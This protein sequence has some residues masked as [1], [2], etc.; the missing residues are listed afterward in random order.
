MY[1]SDEGKIYLINTNM[2][3]VFTGA[4]TNNKECI[5]TLIDGELISHDKNG[6]FI[7]LYAAFDIYYVKKQD[8]RSYTFMLLETEKDQFK[9]RYNVLKYI[10][11]NS[12]LKYYRDLRDSIIAI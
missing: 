5:N 9:A 11:K 10:E 3:V 4:K 2:D 12:T 6:N 8:I 1:I 7:N